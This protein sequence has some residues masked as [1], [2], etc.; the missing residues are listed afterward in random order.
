M[1][2]Y[3]NQN[4]FIHTF[5]YENTLSYTSAEKIWRTYNMHIINNDENEFYVMKFSEQ[6]LRIYFRY[7]TKKEIKYDKEHAAIA[8]E[9]IVTPYKILHPGNPMGKIMASD[10]F[11]LVLKKLHEMFISIEQQTGVTFISKLKIKRIDL[12]CDV[13]TPSILYSREIISVCKA[14]RLRSGYSFWTMTKEQKEKKGWDDRAACLYKNKSRGILGKIYDK[15]DNLSE[16]GYFSILAGLHNKG[17]LRFEITLERQALKKNEILYYGCSNQSLFLVM[18]EAKTLFK[19]YF[20]D[21]FDQGDMLSETLL[22][23]YIKQIFPTQ[24]KTQNDMLELCK[25]YNCCRK[26]SKEFRLEDFPHSEKTLKRIQKKYENFSLSPIPLSDQCPYIPSFTK[27]LEG[28]Y[29]DMLMN[30]ARIH[31]RGKEYWDNE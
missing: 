26:H 4:F 13:M 12:T 25:I 8:V 31:T 11:T 16:L 28:S 17:L 10:Q 30:Y 7:R 2:D 15:K 20:L 3:S 21:V 14:T 9:W 5:S 6:G 29:S 24:K 27:M 1:K 23:R 19:K 18:K 22:G